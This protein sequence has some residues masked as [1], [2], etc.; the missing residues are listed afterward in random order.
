MIQRQ[1]QWNSK[2]LLLSCS[3]FFTIFRSS[4]S[5]TF[6]EES[7]YLESKKLLFY[8]IIML[9]FIYI[10]HI[11]WIVI[12]YLYTIFY[13]I[14]FWNLTSKPVGPSHLYTEWK[15]LKSIKSKTLKPGCRLV[16]IFWTIN[17]FS[18]T[19]AVF[20]PALDSPVMHCTAL[21]C[22]VHCAVLDNITVHYGRAGD[23]LLFSQKY[24]ND[25]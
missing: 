7:G 5:T 8:K 21:Y 2:F 6:T 22:T 25:G 18:D 10:H 1:F 3:G 9:I 16:S 14:I 12:N 15:T 11:I 4:D 19:R 13:K 20:T 24:V 23:T 17:H